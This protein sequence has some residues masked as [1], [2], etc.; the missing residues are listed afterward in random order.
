MKLTELEQKVL[1]RLTGKV[2]MKIDLPVKPNQ[3][4][5]ARDL[6]IRPQSVSRIVKQLRSK[7]V[8]I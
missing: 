7:G 3:A 5:V 8:E 6:N 4:N 1:D 2:K